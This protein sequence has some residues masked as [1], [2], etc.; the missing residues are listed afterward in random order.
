MFII[1]EKRS[2]CILLWHKSLTEHH[3]FTTKA[4][5]DTKFRQILKKKMLVSSIFTW[6]VSQKRWSTS[7]KGS[8]VYLEARRKYKYVC[9]PFLNLVFKF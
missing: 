6:T 2:D 7:Q 9:M 1:E 4:R 8:E 5:K 3:I